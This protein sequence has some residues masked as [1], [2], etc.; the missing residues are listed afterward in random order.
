MFG[1]DDS[2]RL[3]GEGG[4]AKKIFNN[5]HHGTQHQYVLFFPGRNLLGVLRIAVRILF[6]LL[7]NMSRPG[8]DDFPEWHEQ[9][10]AGSA[11]IVNQYCK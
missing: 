6:C 10:T 2:E 11:R 5:M 9:A 1:G 7:R 3:D 8:H 4:G